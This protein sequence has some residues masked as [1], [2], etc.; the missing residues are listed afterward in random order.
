MDK[1]LRF[2]GKDLEDMTFAEWLESKPTD[3]GQIAKKWFLEMQNCGHDVESIIHDGYPIACYDQ[4][5][6]AYV[7]AFTHHVNIG[8][9]YGAELQD[10]YRMLEGSGKRMRHIKVKPGAWTN[11]EGIR[12]MI[13]AAYVDIKIRLIA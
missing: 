6:F 2:S 4:A 11:E 3:L 7:N 13:K 9:F 12:S 1:I 10:P 5:P 8:F